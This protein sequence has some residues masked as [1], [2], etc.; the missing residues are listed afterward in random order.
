MCEYTCTC[1]CIRSGPP[2]PRKNSSFLRSPGFGF[3]RFWTWICGCRITNI[4]HQANV[5]SGHEILLLTTV[6]LQIYFA[7][8]VDFPLLRMGKTWFC[9]RAFNLPIC[10][11]ITPDLSDCPEF[12][13]LLFPP[14]WTFCWA[15]PHPLVCSLSPEKKMANRNLWKGIWF[16]W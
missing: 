3:R 8:L 15:P 13:W 9:I 7:F 6:G 5:L 10:Q 16:W 1:E 4:Q 14:W 12:C 11:S 2:E